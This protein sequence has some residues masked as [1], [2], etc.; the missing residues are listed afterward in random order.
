[1]PKWTALR[2]EIKR[3]SVDLDIGISV[4][5]IAIGSDSLVREN[6]K[7]LGYCTENLAKAHIALY[8]NQVHGFS[9]GK[10]AKVLRIDRRTL[11]KHVRIIAG[12]NAAQNPISQDINA[13]LKELHIELDQISGALMPLLKLYLECDNTERNAAAGCIYLACQRTNNHRTIREI[14][15]AMY[16]SEASVHRVIRKMKN[17]ERDLL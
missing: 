13:A 3:I 16:I 17:T 1:M 4:T 9:L 7:Y 12:L 11:S 8:L 10:S 2:S 15:N 5:D 6:G 14:C